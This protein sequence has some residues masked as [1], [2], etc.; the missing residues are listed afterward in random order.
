MAAR[1]VATVSRIRSPHSAV[2]RMRRA[3]SV[4]CSLE[5]S[6][7]L[8][9]THSIDTASCSSPTPKNS[10]WSW[11]ASGVPTPTSSMTRTCVRKDGP[12]RAS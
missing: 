10:I 3:R 1:G 11:V 12:T 5:G 7:T 8:G 9:D 6:G 2:S 4:L